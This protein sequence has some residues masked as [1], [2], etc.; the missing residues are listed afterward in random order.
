MT[1]L[2]STTKEKRQRKPKTSV[3]AYARKNT[4]MTFW[5]ELRIKNNYNLKDLADVLGISVSRLSIVFTGAQMPSRTF[6]DKCSQLF[7]VDP[8]VGY[9]EF[10][11]G[12]C[13]YC[14]TH[15]KA[16]TIAPVKV[17]PVVAEK[18]NKYVKPSEE[19]TKTNITSTEEPRSRLADRSMDELLMELAGVMNTEDFI[20]LIHSID[21]RKVDWE[22]V[23]NQVYGKIDIKVFIKLVRLKNS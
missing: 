19:T 10:E 17:N 15:G 20:E 5:N 7:G 21:E 16:I 11:N 3:K 14:N 6:S 2:N 18:V 1:Q 12:H 23:F 13:V 9:K 8:E 22:K 4:S